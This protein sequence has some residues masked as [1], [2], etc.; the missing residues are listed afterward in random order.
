[1]ARM[2][3]TV[4]DLTPTMEAALGSALEATGDRTVAHSF[5]FSIVEGKDRGIVPPA[6]VPGAPP[7]H[8]RGSRAPQ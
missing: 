5:L 1:M 4:S 3:A 8:R 6:P 2:V 7:L